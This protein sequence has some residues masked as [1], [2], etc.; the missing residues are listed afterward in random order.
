MRLFDIL[1]PGVA[2][3]VHHPQVGWCKW[4]AVDDYFMLY[5]A[6]GQEEGEPLVADEAVLLEDTWEPAA[7]MEFQPYKGYTLEYTVNNDG[8]YHGTV[9]GI[10]DVVT[11]EGNKLPDLARAFHN[12]VDDYL[13]FCQTRN[14]AP[15]APA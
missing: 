7:Q 11:C 12:S 13:T 14:E 1:K 2:C 9:K 8:S 15:N 4:K 3:D 5:F 10:K 6:E